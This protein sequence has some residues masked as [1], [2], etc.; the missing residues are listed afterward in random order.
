[1]TEV[2]K[3]KMMDYRR[4]LIVCIGERCSPNGEGQALYDQLSNKFKQAGLNAG[5]LRVKRSR[6]TC[7]GTCKSGPLICVQ[8]DGVWYYDVTSEKLDRIIAE[9]FLGGV[10]VADYIYHQVL[11][12]TQ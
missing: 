10:P 8:P 11:E 6:A 1:M 5:D 12:T 3:P 4:H 7:F 9:H 2:I